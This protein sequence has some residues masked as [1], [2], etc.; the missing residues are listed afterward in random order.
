[1][2]QLLCPKGHDSSEQDF[3][4]VC[5]AKMV[6]P[7]APAQNCPDCNAAR[8][9]AEA[10]FCQDCGYNF[11][12][13]LHGEPKPAAQH[14]EATIAVDASLRTDESPAA[15]EAFQPI[16]I[17]L[18]RENNLIGRGSDKRAIFPEI[19]LDFDDAV[20]H[21]HAL[22]MRTE[23]A[24]L[25]LRD[26]GSANGTKLNGSD[27]QPLADIPLKDGDRITLGHWTRITVRTVAG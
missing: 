19:S 25:V 24:G 17:R 8:E 21:R 16:A 15:P 20:S 9:S 18:D 23:N 26:L 7:P 13:G 5:G 10:A 22:I 6:S 12:T 14:W 27:A 4:S 11:T 3:C 1:M 2:P